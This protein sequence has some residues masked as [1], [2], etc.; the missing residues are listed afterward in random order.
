MAISVNWPCDDSIGRDTV[1]HAAFGSDVTS[2]NAPVAS[3]AGPSVLPSCDAA[4][5]ELDGIFSSGAGPL[6]YQW[7]VGDALVGHNGASIGTYFSALPANA[8]YV[9]LASELLSGGDTFS[10]SLHVINILGIESAPATLSV[11]RQLEPA[12]IVIIDAPPTLSIAAS[13]QLTLPAVAQRQ[14]TGCSTAA[15]V[16]TAGGNGV[17]FTWRAECDNSTQTGLAGGSST[18]LLSGATLGGGRTCTLTARGC[19]AYCG[20]A[21]V[22]VT[23]RDAPLVARIAGGD[24]SLARSAE[25]VLDASAS[26]DPDEPDAAMSV[27]WTC[28]APSSLGQG[29]CPDMGGQAGF[30]ATVAGGALETG[31]YIFTVAV[32]TSNDAATASVSITVQ[33]DSAGATPQVT[34]TSGCPATGGK[35]NPSATR[36]PFVGEA[37]L[38]GGNGGA[39]TAAAL[40]ELSFLWSAVAL[41]SGAAVALDAAGATSTG[42]TSKLLGN[43][44]ATSNLVAR[45]QAAAVFSAGA[46]YRFKLTVSLPNALATGS[47]PWTAGASAFASCEAVFNLPPRGCELSVTTAT[48]EVGIELVDDHTIEALDCRDDET[49]EPLRYT[50]VATTADGAVL[51]LTSAPQMSPRLEGVRLPF[52]GDGGVNVTMEAIDQHGASAVLTTQTSVIRAPLTVT[53]VDDVLAS[54]GAALARGDATESLRMGAA[55][56]ASLN[57]EAAETPSTDAGNATNATAQAAQADEAAAVETAARV[58]VIG[59]F[60]SALEATPHDPSALLQVASAVASAVQGNVPEASAQQAASTVASLVDSLAD[61]QQAAAPGTDTTVLNALS[62]LLSGSLAAAASPPSNATNTTRRLS[63]CEG[64]ADDHRRRRLRRELRRRMSEGASE[65]VSDCLLDTVVAATDALPAVMT[66]DTLPDEETQHATSEHIDVSAGLRS[67]AS[68]EG[69]AFGYGEGTVTMPAGWAAGTDGC[70]S[71]AD[72]VEMVV[73]R[74]GAEMSPQVHS[75]A[76]VADSEAEASMGSVLQEVLVQSG[77][78]HSECAVGGL[79]SPIRISIPLGTRQEGSAGGDSCVFQSDCNAPWGACVGGLCECTPLFA[80]PNCSDGLTCHWFAPI[81]DTDGT[82]DNLWSSSGCTTVLPPADELANASVLACDCTHLTEF[83][84]MYVP[85]TASELAEEA[86]NFRFD[87]PCEDGWRPRRVTTE[88]TGSQMLWGLIFGVAGCNAV[89]LPFFWWRYKERRKRKAHTLALLRDKLVGAAKWVSWAAS[90]MAAR[91][92]IIGRSPPASMTA[93]RAIA[94]M[95]VLAKSS[96]RVAPHEGGK[97]PEIGGGGNRDAGE[98]GALGR[99]MRAKGAGALAAAASA[100]VAEQSPPEAQEQPTLPTTPRATFRAGVFMRLL[101]LSRLTRV[102]PAPEP[103]PQPQPHPE[104]PPPAAEPR[105]P[106]PRA[107]VNQPK[108]KGSQRGIAADGTRFLQ[109]VE[110]INFQV[111]SGKPVSEQLRDALSKHAVR[112]IDLFREWDKDETNS[113]DMKEFRKAMRELGCQSPQEEVDA[114]F[115]SFD[116]DGSGQIELPELNALLRRGAGIDVGSQK[117]MRKGSSTPSAP[118]LTTLGRLGV[119]DALAETSIARGRP[120]ESGGGA[121]APTLSAPL[122]PQS[123]SERPAPSPPASPP[124]EG[125]V[126]PTA[127]GVAVSAPVVAPEQVVAR[128]TSCVQETTTVTTTTV[129]T[130]RWVAAAAVGAPNAESADPAAPEPAVEVSTSEQA[131]VS[132]PGDGSSRPKGAAALRAQGSWSP[133]YKNRADEIVGRWQGRKPRRSSLAEGSVSLRAVSE[134]LQNLQI[135]KVMKEKRQE[136]VEQARK[137]HTV[138]S[139]VGPLDDWDKDPAHLRDH[140]TAQIFF[141]IVMCELVVL[142]IMYNTEEQTEGGSIKIIQT[143]VKSSIAAFACLVQAVVLRLTFRWGNALTRYPARKY[144]TRIRLGIAWGIAWLAYIFYNWIVIAYANC[145]MDEDTGLLLQDWIIGLS[146]SFVV[147]EPFAI[148]LILVMPCIFKHPRFLACYSKC[149]EAGI[150]LSMM[151]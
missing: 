74:W 137:V 132:F 145:L 51:R 99:V 126:P 71:G 110:P 43:G 141:N 54:A 97:D 111:K 60:A 117:H 79:D 95:Q 129:T 89:A 115:R 9:A 46:T 24:R 134:R 42:V 133:S 66:A 101:A 148:L 98:A 149:Q 38:V 13:A 12:P 67:A 102:R 73:I 87:L 25:L 80:G 31:E 94:R 81:N 77:A 56:L 28:T 150:D 11:Q 118:T 27:A 53:V 48:G 33:A 69:S 65:G 18:L 70:A 3:L 6:S 107:V 103:E 50:F 59:L 119:G 41:P 61:L 91:R 105:P 127:V 39:P 130:R 16:S 108:V 104:P 93:T 76:T 35:L 144:E 146:V 92:S 14:L 106:P 45:Q 8:S 62:N 121:A 124:E 26:S 32:D 143:I 34:I 85:T 82:G 30:M 128:D 40:G 17:A 140:Q 44:S 19:V 22:E 75:D 114:L 68:L 64:G 2:C 122:Q 116:T 1:G 86:T 72:G 109:G 21:S 131:K 125:S 100:G 96:A 123:Q 47:S 113:V 142:A 37:T 90:E 136:G 139:L 5:I 10:F 63:S 52:V 23:V 78:N 49:D 57:R 4:T 15:N 55:L 112:V 84:G 58:A 36:V 135:A 151:F 83:A 88:G 20:E 138:V 147:M 7:S 29:A 120:T